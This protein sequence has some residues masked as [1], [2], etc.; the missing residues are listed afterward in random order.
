MLSP[1]ELL[2]I[3]QDLAVRIPRTAE[4]AEE[5][6]AT[7]LAVGNACLA[8]D[9]VG[10]AERALRSIDELRVQAPLRM[11]IG[12][13]A[14][15]HEESEVGRRL[16]EETVSQIAELECWVTRK[17]VTDLVPAIFKLLGNEAV[18]MTD[19]QVEDLVAVVEG[20]ADI[21]IDTY[22]GEHHANSSHP[23]DMIERAA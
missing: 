8:S 9:E 23:A 15:S 18:G 16:L 12:K 21:I 14:G 6:N 1:L 17:D 19:A 22:I 20:L 10:K 5:R 7:W 3:A 4:Y 11:E 13:W 2:E